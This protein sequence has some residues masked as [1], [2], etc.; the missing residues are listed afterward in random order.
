MDRDGKWVELGER[1]EGEEGPKEAER[2]RFG[3]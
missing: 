3:V 1:K 2:V